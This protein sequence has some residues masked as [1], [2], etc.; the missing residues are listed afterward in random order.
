MANANDQRFQMKN[1]PIIDATITP[2]AWNAHLGRINLTFMVEGLTDTPANS[3]LRRVLLYLSL[4][5]AGAQKAYHMAPDQRPPAET[6]AQYVE[7]L[8]QIFV[9]RQESDMAKLD[10]KKCKQGKTEAIQTFHARK[11]RLFMDAFRVDQANIANWM[12]QFLDDYLDSIVRREVKMDLLEHK[13]YARP[14]DVLTRAMTSCAKHRA[15]IPAGAPLAAYDGLHSTNH[16]SATA[17]A[18]RT[19]GAAAAEPMELGMFE[20]ETTEDDMESVLAS[21]SYQETQA[22]KDIWEDPSTQIILTLVNS[23]ETRACY[24]CQKVGHLKRDCWR[25]PKNQATAARN[26]V[27]QQ[28]GPQGAARRGARTSFQSGRQ[29]QP[30][31]AYQRTTDLVNNAGWRGQNTFTGPGDNTRSSYLNALYD[32]QANGLHYEAQGADSST[33]HQTPAAAARTSAIPN[34]AKN[35]F[36]ENF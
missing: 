33:D 5:N 12:E 32:I 35:T 26:R 13:P 18:Q 6:Y 19:N 1:L 23:K 25:R 15:L 9:P 31:G 16:Y 4:G 34:G 2:A 27:R 21:L 17:A 8:S 7:A 22:E 24:S 28:G 3:Q 20:P 29:G 30:S 14:E 10:Y 11:V 36:G